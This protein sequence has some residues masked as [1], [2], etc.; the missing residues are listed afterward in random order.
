MYKILVSGL[1]YDGGKSGISN[2]IDNVVRCLA[3]EHEVEVIVLKSD[4][5]TFRKRNPSVK[6]KLQPDWTAK[7]AISALWHLFI[8]PFTIDFSGYDFVFLPA[9]NRRLFCRC[10]K[11][12]VTT[13][14]DL[15]Q[16]HLAGK[17][18]RLRTFYIFNVLRRFLLKV[19]SICAISK[20]TAEDI[21]HFY[22][23]SG[24]K[25]FI[26]YNGFDKTRLEDKSVTESDLRRKYDI[27]GSYLLYV[28]RIEHPGKN[29]LNLIKAYE[30][31]S[32]EIRDKYSLVF[33]GSD[34]NGAQAVHD[35]VRSS[36]VKGRVKFCGFVDDASLSGL[37]RFASL[38]VFPSFCEGFG[39]PMLEAMACGVPVV[40]SNR[41][42]LP[43]I[44][45]DAV[46]TFEPDNVE[47]ISDAIFKLLT[48][49]ALYDK[50][51]SNGCNRIKEF[52]WKKHAQRI[53][54]EYERSNPI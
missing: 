4:A 50:L 28:A 17:Y 11:W 32:P 13:F 24:E 23:I 47:Q 1:A 9:G 15:S 51:V 2:Y 12:C 5:D 26:N 34:W 30:K 37:Y 8:L 43:E 42:S 21:K 6:L 36:P 45:G 10:P 25:I 18:D 52:D 7:P 38:Y 27:E 40:C 46:L 39:I 20:S 14:H 53:V 49:R 22:N 44:G 48:D 29:H 54:K 19:D 31:L 35:Y 33:A 16:F 41:T 3:D